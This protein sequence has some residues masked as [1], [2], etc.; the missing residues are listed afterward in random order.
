MIAALIRWSVGN[1]FLVLSR[2]SPG[3]PKIFLAPTGGGL[4]PREQAGGSPTPPQPSPCQGRELST[5]RTGSP[6][7]RGA[8]G[9]KA[10]A[11]NTPFRRSA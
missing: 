6:L 5:R 4:A 7:S 11:I 9:V 8:G 1:R 3:R 2:K 10:L